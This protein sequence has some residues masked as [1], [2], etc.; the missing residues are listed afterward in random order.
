L[1]QFATESKYADQRAAL[2]QA[3]DIKTPVQIY[4]NSY[5]K[6]FGSAMER[7]FKA[8]LDRITENHDGDDTY[9]TYAGVQDFS[10]ANLAPLVWAMLQ[11]GWLKTEDE[12]PDKQDCLLRAPNQGGP[13]VEVDK[14]THGHMLGCYLFWDKVQGLFIRT[15]KDNVLGNRPK[16]HKNNLTKRRGGCGLVTGYADKMDDLNCFVGLASGNDL[17][18]VEVLASALQWPQTTVTKL[19][20]WNWPKKGVSTVFDR[21]KGMLGYLVEKWMELCCDY[22]VIVSTRPGWEA[23]MGYFPRE[24]A[25]RQAGASA[26]RKRRNTTGRGAKKSK[27]SE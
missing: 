16:T 18:A 5:L 25:K 7:R 20:A 22:Q 10:R 3:Y 4:P 2:R 13:S 24:A 1:Q 11:L 9:A 21:V 26:K 14:K 17:T 27:N 23:P 19:Q 12:D 6:K 8:D 15:G